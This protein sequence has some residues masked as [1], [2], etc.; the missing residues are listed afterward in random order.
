[1]VAIYTLHNVKEELIKY[2]SGDME[3]AVGHICLFKSILEK[4]NFCKE[5]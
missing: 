3:L 4:C 1:M 5:Q 2:A